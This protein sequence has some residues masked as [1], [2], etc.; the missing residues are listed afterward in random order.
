MDLQIQP[1]LPQKRDFRIGILGSGFLVNEGHLPAYRKAGFNPVAIA[2]R[3]REEAE[4]VAQRHGIPKVFDTC[5]DLLN[6]PSIEVLDIAVP[7]E[8]PRNLILRACARKTVRGILVQ[9]PLGVEYGVAAIAVSA[10][11]QAGIV[12]SVNQFMR[13]DPSVRAAK[14]LLQSGTF[15]EPVFATFEMR[16]LPGW[17]TLP[18]GLGWS[19]LRLFSVHHLD[20]FRHWFGDPEGIYCSIRADPRSKSY[21]D[22]ICT[23]ILEYADG[24]RCVGVDN[25]IARPAQENSPADHY[26]RWRIEGLNGLANGDIGWHCA[27]PF[28]PSTIKFAGKGDEQFHEPKWT[29]SWLPDAFI[30][31]MAQ[32][33]IALE[34]GT[35]PAI[36][37]TDYLKTLALVEAASHSTQRFVSVSLED[38][39]M[40]P[41]PAATEKAE[42]TE[43]PANP[44]VPEG[45]KPG[46]LGR[47]LS[48]AGGIS[49]PPL[50]DQMIPNFTP[51]TQQVLALARKEAER[52]NHNFVGTEHVLLGL[53]ALDRGVAVNVLKKLGLDLAKV[54]ATVEKVVGTG[55]GKLLKDTIPPY[56]PRVKRALALAAKEA[57][58]L[59]HAYVGTEHILLGLMKEGDGVAAR[60]LKDFGVDLEKTRLEILKELDPNFGKSR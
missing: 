14:T 56:T 26:L 47:L 25:P 48:R 36:S 45:R 16:G 19:T 34:T 21:A 43:E 49:S 7:L 29:E 60:V 4:Q 50:T 53:I 54:R 41:F 39:K 30:G 20:C 24:L 33:L 32:L 35:E 58:N 38:V 40:P 8:T 10:C 1:P 18:T 57:K 2:S 9:P 12:L 46:F 13:Y 51:R 42:Q 31:T 52:F 22:G 28:P 11:Q 23:F 15:G 17:M 5:E 27:P 3:H 55:P 6:D 44:F 37:A 59:E